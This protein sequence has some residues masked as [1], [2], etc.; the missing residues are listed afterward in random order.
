MQCKHKTFLFQGDSGGPLVGMATNGNIEV[1]GIVSW[2][3]DC[4]KH[5]APGS[6]TN[7]FKYIDFI[8]NTISS[9]NCEVQTS[10][11]VSDTTALPALST[12]QPASPEVPLVPNTTLPSMY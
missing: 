9:G 8:Q 4:A 12:S 3:V 5:N 6:Y 11:N 2:G 10:P 7:V 1:V